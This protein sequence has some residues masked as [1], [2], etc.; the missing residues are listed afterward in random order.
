MPFALEGLL[1]QRKGEP[2]ALLLELEELLSVEESLAVDN[3]E[4][5]YVNLQALELDEQLETELVLGLLLFGQSPK[6][7]LLLYDLQELD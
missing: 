2:V 5:I 6:I 3:V 1:G 7:Y 4:E